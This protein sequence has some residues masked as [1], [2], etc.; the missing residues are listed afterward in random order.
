MRNL[1]TG[2]S[3]FP[4]TA[5]NDGLHIPGMTLR[6]YFA[7]KAFQGMLATEQI[8][9][10]VIGRTITPENVANACYDWADEMLKARER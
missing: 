10:M 6:D 2:G 3:A 7:A 5:T 8:Q 1:N 9:Q 4:S